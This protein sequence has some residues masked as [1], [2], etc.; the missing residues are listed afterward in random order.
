MSEV[1]PINLKAFIN[2][3]EGEVVG[4]F[5]SKYFKL[6]P[7]TRC[8]DI[9]VSAIRLEV[10]YPIGSQY[11]QRPT[12]KSNDIDTAFPLSQ[13]PETLFGGV[14]DRLFDD[15]AITF[16]SG[17]EAGDQVRTNGLQLDQMQN[18]TGSLS[19]VLGLTGGV[20]TGAFS[21]SSVVGVS[22]GAGSGQNNITVNFNSANS[23]NVR[24]G[25]Q[26]KGKN[27][28]ELTWIRIS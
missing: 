13:R 6:D 21:S 18:I 8:I 5:N 28:I 10:Q 25:S 3:S 14:W 26:T 11:I 15:E 7:E 17:D 19:S 1:T 2:T 9:D 12:V 24:T 23:L 4:Y 20:Y 16:Y 22:I 27:R